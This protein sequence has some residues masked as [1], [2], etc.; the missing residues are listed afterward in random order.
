MP[1]YTLSPTERS[2][3]QCYAGLALPRHTSYPVVPVCQASYGP[4]EFRADLQRSAA[5]QRPLSLYVHLPFCEKLCYYCACTKEIIP[6][7]RT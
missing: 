4:A 5:E 3:Y 1:T 2:V 6:P 7:A